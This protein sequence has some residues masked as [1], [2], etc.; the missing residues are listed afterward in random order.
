M[1]TLEKCAEEM[2]KTTEYMKS[3]ANIALLPHGT[4]QERKAAKN[5]FLFQ[6]GKLAGLRMLS[7]SLA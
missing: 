1:L 3:A 2:A 4:K 5:D 7:C 6:S